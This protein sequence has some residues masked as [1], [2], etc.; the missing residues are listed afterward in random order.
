MHMSEES[1]RFEVLAQLRE[2][3]STFDW[4]G[5]TAGRKQILEA[6]LRIATTEGYTSVTM[7]AL[8]KQLN[9]KAPSLYSH[10]PDGRDQV[11]GMALRWH[12]SRWSGDA[13]SA[14]EPTTG[15]REFLDALIA[16][17]VRSQLTRQEND[18]FDL[19]L[20]TDRISGKL[21]PDVRAEADRLTSLYENL[22][23]GAIQDLGY[24]NAESTAAVIVSLLDGVRSW[25][26]WDGDE[27]LLDRIVRTAKTISYSIL[28]S[29]GSA[30][31]AKV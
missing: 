23:A 27:L 14:L 3:L 26:K 17:H 20:A 24:A 16:H 29:V 8:G 19:L 2:T 6:F 18:M 7:R 22:F 28:E 10:F 9:V 15:P 25:S 1:A 4:S 31:V 5:L 13:I 30:A 12:Y 11:V 21:P